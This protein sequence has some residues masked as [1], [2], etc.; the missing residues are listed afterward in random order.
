MT[1]IHSRSLGHYNTSNAKMMQVFALEETN[2]R[3][4]CQYQRFPITY[5]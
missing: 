2:Q 1:K 5:Q 3:S 4:R